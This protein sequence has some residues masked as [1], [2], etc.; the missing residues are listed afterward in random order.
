MSN[1]SGGLSMNSCLENELANL[2]API[3]AKSY[4]P[5]FNQ[6]YKLAF[7]NKFGENQISSRLNLVQPIDGYVKT[8]ETSKKNANIWFSL[9]AVMKHKP[10]SIAHL[11]R[12]GFPT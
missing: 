1:P 7:L 5:F 9:T 8:R 10:A 3:Y 12:S 6:D 4:L 2:T 11:T